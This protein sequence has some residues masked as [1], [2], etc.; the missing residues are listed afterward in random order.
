MIREARARLPADGRFVFSVARVEALSLDDRAFDFVL[1]LHMLSHAESVS[2][3]I[4]ELGR[5]LRTS[6]QCYVS[7][8]S[9]SHLS[10]L[11]ELLL[12]Y[13]RSLAFPRG[14]MLSFLAED[15]QAHLGQVFRSVERRSFADHL[16]I[17]DP[18]AIVRYYLSI[19]DGN[20]YP[21]LRGQRESLRS[22]VQRRIT[23]RGAVETESRAD[24]FLCRLE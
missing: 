2:R 11:R 12:E 7:T 3:A 13:D 23:D 15:A 17:N 8:P 21:D 1:A 9:R 22:H 18:E 24:L 10:T 16:A 19:F 4:S 6:G 5:V 20:G 14:R